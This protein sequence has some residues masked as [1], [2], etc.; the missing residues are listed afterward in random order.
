MF[1][2]FCFSFKIKPVIKIC[3]NKTIA[4][5]EPK[6][7]LYNMAKKTWKFILIWVL[8]LFSVLILFTFLHECGH[9]FGSQLDGTHVSTGFNRVG[10]FG[11]KPSDP[12]FHLNQ[13]TLG[14]IDASG[15]LGP[16]TNWIFAIIF[17][18]LLATAKEPGSKN[19]FLFG[20]CAIANALNRLLPMMWFFISALFHHVHLEDEVEWGARSISSLHFPMPNE[21]FTALA[22][23]QPMLFLSDPLF[24]FWPLV[25]ITISVVCFIVAYRQMFRQFGAYLPSK[26][27]KVFWGIS[28]VL[29]IPF[30]FILI[31]LLDNLIRI[32]W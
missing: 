28:P 2:P 12:D 1:L 4:A 14:T 17:T 32:S 30:W 6:K 16:F 3:P 31:N 26:P 24:Y 5:D 10:D 11:K 9:G 22:N 21:T 25:S 19:S 8:I 7:E 20:A 23:A 15:L 13:Y 27:T 29:A 18:V